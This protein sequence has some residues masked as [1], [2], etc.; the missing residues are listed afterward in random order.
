MEWHEYVK[1]HN[2][3]RAIEWYRMAAEQGDAE[4]AEQLC[5]LFRHVL[6]EM[7]KD[8]ENADKDLMEEISGELEEWTQALSE[9]DRYH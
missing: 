3:L 2:A 4:A 6:E 9:F 8:P 5:I 7:Q 1:T